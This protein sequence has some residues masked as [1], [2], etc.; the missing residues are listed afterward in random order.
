M[1]V[2]KFSKGEL[3]KLDQ[4]VKREFRSKQVLGKQ[5]S[6]KRLYLKREDGGSGLKLMR[7][8]FKETILRVACYMSKSENR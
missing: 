4:I 5:A 3:T 2:C 1:N 8:V 7:D 6:N